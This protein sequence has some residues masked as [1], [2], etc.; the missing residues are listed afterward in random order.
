MNL[1]IGLVALFLFFYTYIFFFLLFFFLWMCMCMLLCVIFVSIALLLLFVLR[2]CLFIFLFLFLFIYFLSSFLLSPV[3]DR[4]FTFW[5]AVGP[6]PLGWKG[7]AWDI[8]PPG[9][10]QLHVISIRESSPRDLCLN[11]K[12]HPYSMAS[13]LQCR[14]SHTK[15]LARQEHKPTH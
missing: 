7:W 13:K 5:L 11:T 12:T 8:G 3:A 10:S 2:F 15:Q 14:M 1:F 6:E 9:T 4:V